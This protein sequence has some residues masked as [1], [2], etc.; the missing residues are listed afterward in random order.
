[1]A[2]KYEVVFLD[3]SGLEGRRIIEAPSKSQAALEGGAYAGRGG[4]VLSAEVFVPPSERPPPPPPPAP[5]V[6]TAADVEALA[7][8]LGGESRHL[9]PAEWSSVVAAGTVRGVAQAMLW[10]A[11]GLLAAILV[12]GVDLSAMFLFALV[13]M[14][15]AS[16]TASLQLPKN[17][18]P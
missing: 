12:A 4:R 8:Q 2:Q 6:L 16:A 7:R 9:G 15:L 5:P 10:L 11:L 14:I 13:A 3:E 1:M 18:R 17:R